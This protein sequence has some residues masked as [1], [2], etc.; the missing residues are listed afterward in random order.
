MFENSNFLKGRNM[1][2]RTILKWAGMFTLLLLLTQTAV[3][4]G[5]YL[6]ESDLWQGGKSIINESVKAYVEY[7]VYDAD[8]DLPAGILNP[9]SGRYV[10]AYQI[11]NYG[12]TM[13]PI[14][15][16][17]LVGG[18]P[19]AATGIGSQSDGQGGLV[20]DN[21]GDT[22]VWRFTNGTFIASKHSAFLVF[23]SEASPVAG[24]L[25]VLDTLSNYGDEPPINEGAIGTDGANI[26]EPTTVTLLTIGALSLLK[27]R[28]S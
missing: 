7:A 9:G 16:F 10:Y 4:A 18:N 1:K 6:P 28:R 5:F 11:F 15:Q 24:D 13:D 3:Q 23:S 19:A 25:R 21:D 12:T 2:N 8:D 22:F 26:P 27:R 20:P 17:E 14:L